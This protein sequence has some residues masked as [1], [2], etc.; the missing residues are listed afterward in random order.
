[1]PVLE[2]ENNLYQ[3]VHILQDDQIEN[4][5]VFE[6]PMPTLTKE[7][8]DDF[9]EYDPKST[10]G[11][12]FDTMFDS[13]IGEDYREFT[14]A[15]GEGQH[16]LSLFQDADCEYL[17][18]PSIYCG[19]KMNT[20]TADGKPIH[21]A[22]Q[23]KWELTHEDRRA[24]NCIP[25]L[26]F[27]AK[28][29]QIKQVLNKGTFAMKRLQ[30]DRQ[31]TATE[32]MDPENL[33]EIQRFDDGSFIFKHIRN[34]PPYLYLCRKE[35]HA[36]I[37]QLGTPTWFI[38]LSAADTKWLDLLD[39]LRLNDDEDEV[40]KYKDIATEDLPWTYT[41]K[42]VAKNPTICARYFNYRSETFIN[43]VLMSPHNPIG[44]VVDFGYRIEFQH[45][46]E[47][48]QKSFCSYTKLAFKIVY[49]IFQNEKCF[50]IILC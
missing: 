12:N 17:S 24:A 15:P 22:T 45:R 26:F 6:R 48:I 33:S 34:S 47:S 36:M 8:D 46:G 50:C 49:I 27:K 5:D 23:V 40:V 29:L 1:M 42:L 37:R 31:Y 18:F 38:S 35:L 21:Y 44:E 3:E 9:I 20:V 13:G 16:P 7:T 10:E 41:S 28:K 11:G 43:N 2:R 39:M 30:G 4:D 19:E 32:I 14:F 25:N